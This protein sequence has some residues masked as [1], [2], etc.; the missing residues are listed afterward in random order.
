MSCL[1]Y[2]GLYN[3][4]V[5]ENNTLEQLYNNRNSAEPQKINYINVSADYLKSVN[6]IMFWIYISLCCVF[7]WFI[8]NS[9]FNEY[10]KM[11]II[12]F[13]FGF[14]W[15][16]YPLQQGLYIFYMFIIKIISSSVYD[17]GYNTDTTDTTPHTTP[18]PTTPAPT[19]PAPTTPAPTT[20][21]PT[22]P[23]P[24]TPAPTTPAPT[25]PAPDTYSDNGTRQGRGKKKEKKDKKEKNK[26]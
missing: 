4:I 2:E 3:S 11:T 17:D 18:A 16:I 24:T 20:P 14:P 13:A 10:I 7:S 1:Y 21:A 26:D 22:T 23:A 15:Y 12:L 8:Y 25:T 19:T 9:D 5:A 6:K